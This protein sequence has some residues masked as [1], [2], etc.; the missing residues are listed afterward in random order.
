MNKSVRFKSFETTR[1]S[2]VIRVPSKKSLLLQHNNTNTRLALRTVNTLDAIDEE[3]GDEG[4]GCAHQPSLC[5]STHIMGWL[6]DDV[7]VYNDPVALSD[8][9]V[10][11]LVDVFLRV[12]FKTLQPANIQ[13]QL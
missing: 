2:Q 4:E 12:G 1:V 7:F 6:T 10:N 8:R 11:V 3:G 5:A 9:E 13:P